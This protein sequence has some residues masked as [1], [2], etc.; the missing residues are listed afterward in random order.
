MSFANRLWHETRRI[1]FS[2]LPF[3]RAVSGGT[4]PLPVL[5]AYAMDLATLATGFPRLLSRI[6]A[7]CDDRAGRHAVIGNLLEEEGIE[8]FGAEG[9]RVCA[10][11]GHGERARA[12]ARTFGVGD[13]VA[14]PFQQSDWIDARLR[15]GQWLGPLAFVTV[16]YEANVP[17]A[18]TPLV[19]GLRTHYGY[20]DR[21][22]E[23]LIAHVT[24]D[25]EHGAGG[26]EMIDRVASTPDM[27]REA[28]E[29]ARRGTVAFYHLHRK[30]AQGL[31][32]SG[33][34]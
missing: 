21:D 34:A 30:H 4:C 25:A 12:L 24:A 28:L 14:L 17:A 29:G 10:A 9:L 5:Q 3:V 16:G 26:V 20:S 1:D 11:G 15:A 7:L 22:L 31:K 27:Q 2:A 18:F 23:Y 33:A 32:S 8:S 19:E 6:L 13:E